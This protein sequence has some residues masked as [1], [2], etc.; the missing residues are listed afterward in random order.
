MGAFLP[1]NWRPIDSND[2]SCPEPSKQDEGI[3][4]AERLRVLTEDSSILIQKLSTVAGTEPAKG[5]VPGIISV[6]AQWWH[7]L[8]KSS[9]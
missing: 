7:E 6:F 3:G 2:F 9:W 8:R 1:A 4:D 5:P